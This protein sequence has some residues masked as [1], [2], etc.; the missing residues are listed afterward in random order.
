MRACR[1]GGEGQIYGKLRSQGIAGGVLP[2]C[3]GRQ[4]DT[5]EKRVMHMHL[6]C[7]LMRMASQGLQRPVTNQGSWP[8][9]SV[10][11][12]QRPDKKFRQGFMGAPA[13]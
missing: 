10:K 7:E 1:H 2:K 13:A 6:G 8:P 5:R 4:E 11:I 12:D 3:A 9:Q